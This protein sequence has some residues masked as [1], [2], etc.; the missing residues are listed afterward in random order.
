MIMLIFLITAVIWMM[1]SPTHFRMLFS[2]DYL[3]L[4]WVF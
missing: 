2:S 4:I 3:N 1:T